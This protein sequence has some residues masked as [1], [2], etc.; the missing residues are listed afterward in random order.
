MQSF[1]L[2]LDEFLMR[3][4]KSDEFLRHIVDEAKDELGYEANQSLISM[5]VE[6]LKNRSVSI[7]FANHSDITEEEVFRQMTDRLNLLFPDLEREDLEQAL[8]EVMS[9]PSKDRADRLRQILEK[10]RKEHGLSE[11]TQDHESIL[12]DS[13]RLFSF[14]S[15]ADAMEFAHKSALGGAVKSDLYRWKNRYYLVVDHYRIS[16][17][18]FNKLTAMAFDFGKVYADPEEEFLGLTAQGELLISQKAYATLRK[19]Y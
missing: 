14:A 17:K 2:D 7:T 10:I 18:R 3:S 4:K 8:V 16:E 19:L 11:Y 5:R 6:V 15:L 9:M 1:G 12:R 13:Y